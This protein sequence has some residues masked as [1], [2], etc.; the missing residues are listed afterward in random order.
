MF[1]ISFYYP[2][3]YLCYPKTIEVLQVT[4]LYAVVESGHLKTGAEQA[5]RSEANIYFDQAIS[6]LN[7]KA[8]ML[9]FEKK[10][11]HKCS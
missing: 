1:R 8:E 11:S 3:D 2:F 6:N 9:N 7:R 4:I 10:R 5:E